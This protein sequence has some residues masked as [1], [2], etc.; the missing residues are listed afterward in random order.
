MNSP[1]R[2]RDCFSGHGYEEYRIGPSE[3]PTGVATFAV[4]HM[5]G[6]S[7]EELP[8]L[9]DSVPVDKLDAVLQEAQ[10]R[11]CLEFEY[12]DYRICTDGTVLRVT[13]ATTGSESSS[14]S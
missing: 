7:L 6:R 2:D 11:L 8:S 14:R 9:R 1:I 3:S 13:S 10:A 12:H 4:A 5:T